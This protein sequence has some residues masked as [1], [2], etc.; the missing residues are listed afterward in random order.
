M[1]VMQ[2]RAKVSATSIDLLVDELIHSSTPEAI[3]SDLRAWIAGSRRFRTFVEAHRLKIRK[4][5]RANDTGAALDV[6]AEL[7][8]A[9]RLLADRRIELDFEAYGASEGGPDFTVTFRR[10]ARSLNLEVTRLRQSPN[11]SILAGT[12]L[13][14]LRQ[15]PPAVPN[16]VLVC[17][18]GEAGDRDAVGRAVAGL[19][20]RADAKDDAFFAARGLADSRGFHQRLQRL[21]AVLI[22]CETV[23]GGDRVSLWLNPSPR[24]GLPEPAL[25]ACVGA[26][27]A[28]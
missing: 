10:A 23:E 7:S 5:L 11:A 13:T 20:T 14:K 21:A 2:R 16:V 9:Y 25:R 22:W 19:R 8:V 26:L 18:P 28:S 4:K 6:R 1:T 15:L 3:A 12:L 27:R 17:P 24:V